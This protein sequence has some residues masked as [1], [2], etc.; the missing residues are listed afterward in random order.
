VAAGTEGGDGAFTAIV[1]MSKMRDGT[2]VIEDVLRGHWGALE[3]EKYIKQW[4]DSTRDSLERTSV[5]FTVVIEQEPG[6]GGKE[7]AE[8]T[9][10]N[11][12]GHI[13]IAD[14]PGAGRSKELRAEPFAAQVQGGNVWLHAGPWIVEE[15]GNWPA[16]PSKDQIDAAAQGFFYSPSSH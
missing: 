12:A 15:A 1:I 10:R 3:R 8:A 2:F 11:L 14:K 4:A 9:I 6:S 5:R 7:S 16:S 13:C